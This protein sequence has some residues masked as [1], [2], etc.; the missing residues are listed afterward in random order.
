MARFSDN[1]QAKSAGFS[2][3]ELIVVIV[4]LGILTAI[5]V[6][7]VMDSSA[8]ERAASD[9]LKAHLR[10]AQMQALNSDDSWGIESDSGSYF[11]YKVKDIGKKAQIPG[12][13]EDVVS[14][15]SVIDPYPEFSISFDGWGRPY[16]VPD[17]SNSNPI[18][19]AE[20]IVI[21]SGSIEIEI[22]PE[23][24]FIP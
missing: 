18:H 6:P 14:F 21:V 20:I 11:L 10:F 16:N 4:L 17:P 3:F 24:G 8:Q 19:A 22:F 7:R 15:P 13:Q 23:T 2:F 1:F 12:E 5:A 9:K